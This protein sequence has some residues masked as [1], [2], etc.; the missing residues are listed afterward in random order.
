[1]R[2]DLLGR[3]PTH[4]TEVVAVGGL[5]A[6]MVYFL[7]TRG[8]AEAYPLIALFLVATIRTLPSLQSAWLCMVRLRFYLPSLE[9]IEEEFAATAPAPPRTETRLQAKASIR[10]RDVRFRYP[11]SDRPV[12]EHADLE[13]RVPGSTALVGRTG[14]GKTTLADLAAGLL[15]PE[16]GALEIDGRPLQPHELPA[17]QRNVGYVPQSVYLLDDTLR[18]NIAFGVPDDAVDDRA[19]QEAA[20]AAHLHD[21]LATLPRGYD[22]VLGERGVRLSGGQRQRIGIARALYRSPG[23][24]IL[25]EATNALDSL[26]QREVMEAVEELSATR[27]VLVIAHRLST[28]QGC[29]SLCMVANGRVEER[30]TFSELVARSAAFRE[31]VAGEMG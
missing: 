31:L 15:E 9:R 14:A 27:A 17:W 29:G 20:A 16:G 8:P 2:G 28:V 19:L 21:L 5:L 25:D 18:R 13:L 4:L 10:L 7:A 1:M 6:F 26:T 12:L 24:L 22:T 3:L 11:G 30:G 23:L